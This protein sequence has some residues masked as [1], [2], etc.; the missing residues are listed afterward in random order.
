MRGFQFADSS[1]HVAPGRSG[2]CSARWDTRTGVLQDWSKDDFEAACVKH[3]RIRGQQR[4]RDVIMEIL[5]RDRM[6]TLAEVPRL[7]YAPIITA[8]VY[9]MTERPNAYV[10]R[11]ISPPKE[12]A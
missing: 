2:R 10:R 8:L 7:A 11:A 4:T 3:Q 6:P 9:D 5:D 12:E 1:N